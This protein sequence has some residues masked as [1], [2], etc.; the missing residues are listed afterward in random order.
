MRLL[1]RFQRFRVQSARSKAVS[2]P[3][4]TLEGLLRSPHFVLST[5]SLGL[6]NETHCLNHSE[7]QTE[8]PSRRTDGVAAVSGPSVRHSGLGLRAR[9]AA[10]TGLRRAADLSRQGSASNET[11]HR[12]WDDSGAW[13]FATDRRRVSLEALELERSRES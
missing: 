3:I 6:T 5:P 4:R 8:I 11:A 13:K 1:F 10:L 2:S 12:V 7:K 9:R